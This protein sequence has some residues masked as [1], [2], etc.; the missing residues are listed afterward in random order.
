MGKQRKDISVEAMQVL[1]EKIK[2]D[3]RSQLDTPQGATADTADIDF[4]CLFVTGP[5]WLKSYCSQDF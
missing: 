3:L 5:F 2:A 1:S 4:L